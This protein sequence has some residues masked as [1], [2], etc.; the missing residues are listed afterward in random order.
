MNEE[1][2]KAIDV[3]KNLVDD[4]DGAEDWANIVLNKEE[5]KSLRTIK[6]LI[7]KQRK[8]IEERDKYNITT[9]PFEELKEMIEQNKNI[10]IFGK[11]YVSKDKIRAMLEEI[12]NTGYPYTEKVLQELLGEY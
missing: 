3:F 12:R 8:E 2:K 4:L 5:L 10:S 1:K 9:L 11:E 7:E 6:N